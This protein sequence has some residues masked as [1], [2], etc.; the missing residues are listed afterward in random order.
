MKVRTKYLLFVCMLHL[1]TLVLSFYIFRD[2]MLFFLA[3]EVFIIISLVISWQ[4]YRALIQ[5][6]RLLAQ[7]VDAIKDKDFNVKFV[8]TGKYEIDQLIQVYNQMMDALRTERTRQEQQHFFLEKLIHT[9][10]T[11]ILILDYDEHL[12]QINPRALQLLGLTEM[13]ITGRPIREL[14]HPVLQQVS[15][16]QT[17]ESATITPDGVNT[18]KLQKA[19][20]VDRGFPRHFVMIEKLTEEILAAEKKSVWTGNPHDGT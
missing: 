9:S 18:F 20:F 5:P 17:G 8:A 3:T 10:P 1:I 19:H 7:G 4:L 6:L 16:M 13:E 15:R 14:A 12:R 11:G 2:N